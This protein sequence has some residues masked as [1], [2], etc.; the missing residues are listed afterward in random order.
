M[1]N[2]NASEPLKRREHC[3]IAVRIVFLSANTAKP[4]R[5]GEFYTRPL[6]NRSEN[7]TFAHAARG[8]QAAARSR[9][10]APGASRQPQNAAR[11]RQ[12]HPGNRQEAASTQS[13]GQKSCLLDM[14]TEKNARGGCHSNFDDPRGP[15]SFILYAWTNFF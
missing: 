4:Q 1:R 15:I 12:G 2:L 7:A 14:R 10:G 11:G 5:E 13:A 9:Q 6:L 8:T 3:T